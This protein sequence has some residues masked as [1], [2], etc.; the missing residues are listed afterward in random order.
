[1]CEDDR[2]REARNDEVDDAFGASSL[3]KPVAAADELGD[4]QGKIARRGLPKIW[5][6]SV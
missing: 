6:G 3:N 1:M 4:G 5:R 2:G